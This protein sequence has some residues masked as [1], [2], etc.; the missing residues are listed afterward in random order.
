MITIYSP[1]ET[2]FTTNGL[3]VLQPLSCDLSITINEVW[4]IEL[5]QPI[6]EDGKYKTIEKNNILK[7]TDI[8]VVREQTNTYQLFRIYDTVNDIITGTVKAIAFPVAFEAT[9]DAII[10]E[11]KCAKKTA[12]A[13]LQDI[14]TYLSEHGVTKYTVTSDYTGVTARQRKG[15]WTNT[16][17]IAA[18]NGSDDGS[19]INHWGGEVAYDNYHIIVNGKLGADSNAEIRCGK[20]LTG[21]SVDADMSG[22]VTR[23]YPIS[24]DNV[25]LQ[26]PEGNAT[27]P[28]V[29][30][31]HLG[32]YP[33]V[34]AAFIKTDDKLVD[35][36]WEANAVNTDAAIYTHQAQIAITNKVKEYAQTLWVRIC[37]GEQFNNAI[38]VEPEWLKSVLNDVVANLQKYF[39]DSITHPTW[40]NLIKTCIKDG[41]AWIKDEEI[42]D[43]SW[44][45]NYT[46]GYTYGNTTRTFKNQYVY[47]DKRYRYFNP[48]GEYEPW[49]DVSIMDWIQ[50]KNSNTKEKFG[51][52]KRYMA[53]DTHVY[54]W[55]GE[56]Q[57]GSTA[58]EYW[59]DADGM[60]DGV[61]ETETEWDWHDAGT[62]WWF[63]EDGASESDKNKYAHDCWLYIW[64]SS[65]GL[66]YFDEK[67]KLVDDLTISNPNWDWREA[68]K[69]GKYYFGDSDKT[70]NSVYLHDQWLRIDGIWRKFDSNG[71][72][73]KHDVIKQ[74]L[75]TALKNAMN[76]GLNSVIT[77]QRAVLDDV[78]YTSMIEQCNKKFEEGYDLPVINITANIVDLSKTAEYADFAD[79]ET[80]HLGDRIKVIDYV[81]GFHIYE[82]VVGLKYDCIR[83]YNTEVTINDPSRLLSQM[84]L[85]SNI[86]S[87]G[88][89]TTRMDYVAGDNV[90][91]NNNV[92]NVSTPSGDVYA[93]DQVSVSQT[94]TRGR[95]IAG[96]YVNGVETPIYGGNDVSITPRLNQGTKVADYSIDG[97]SGSL[98]APSGL[99]Y[100]VET[101]DDI[102]RVGQREGL[103]GDDS[104]YFTSA[105]W[106]NKSTSTY[107]EWNYR[108]IN[109]L[110]TLAGVSTANYVLVSIYPTAVD[111]K[112]QQYGGSWGDWETP[113]EGTEYG[114]FGYKPC[115]R[116]Y[117][118]TYK[119]ITWYAARSYFLDGL[120][121]TPFS[122]IPQYEEEVQFAKGLIDTAHAD[123]YIDDVFGISRLTHSVY[124]NDDK[125]HNYDTPNRSD[126]WWIGKDG[127]FN[128][129]DFV[130][131]GTSI[132]G[133]QDVEVDGVSVVSNHVAEIDLSGKQ[134]ALIA[135]TNIDIGADGKTISATDTTYDE[136]TGATALA[137][138]TY[139]LVTKPL[140][141]DQDKVLHGDGTWRE[142]QG[143]SSEIVTSIIE[144]TTNFVTKY[145]SSQTVGWSQGGL[146]YG[147]TD[148]SNVGAQAVYNQPISSDVK[149]V[150]FKI[151]TNLHYPPSQ[152]DDYKV[153]IGVKSTY[154]ATNFA[155]PTDNDWL[156][157]KTY[158]VENGVFE[159][160]LEV[161][162]TGDYY[163]YI[164]GNSWNMTLFKLKLV[165]YA[166]GGGGGSTITYGVNPPS[167]SAND[168]DLHIVLD[169]AN[170][171]IAEFL[172]MVNTWNL[173]SGAISQFSVVLSRTAHNSSQSSVYTATAE[174]DVLVFNQNMN[175]EASNKN[176]TAT[177]ATTGTLSYEDT[178]STNFDNPNRN[179]VSHIAVVHLQAGETVT[180]GNSY[181]GN[182]TTQ[183]HLV[184]LL[185]S[186]S[187]TGISRK[188]FGAKADNSYSSA[189]TYTLPEANTYFAIGFQCRGTG[190]GTQ[191]AEISC[192]DSA[193]AEIEEV[194]RADSNVS[195]SV[196]IVK[197][198]N[199]ITFDWG[200]QNDYA[201]KG[202]AVY[203]LN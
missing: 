164:I 34:R 5:I 39:T 173:I 144:N 98:Y 10:E 184:L 155:N 148:N 23:L 13:A 203:K 154:D 58:C 30:S 197:Y 83:G 95:K 62:Y 90:T 156:V 94:I 194:K 190:G 18:I 114:D 102:Y 142:V 189:Q 137:D 1:S 91:I 135:G 64:R 116:H 75:I 145:N 177:I 187:V 193:N 174:C 79:L 76:T 124:Y 35:T 152:T 73:V 134:D 92:I 125:I 15:S 172:Y 86:G 3:A 27:V 169:N 57:G 133:V 43:Y 37:A 29:D 11:L 115:I 16:N 44:D 69:G 110:P 175:G 200:S 198:A 2:N 118:F 191:Y 7:I 109:N 81:H 42:E 107:K 80:I 70:Q 46:D 132:V 151:S 128:G 153:C 171:K 130:I 108:K 183:L 112:F 25:R 123:G 88:S 40:K 71:L 113:V 131:D 185:N 117:S 24:S 103:K 22:V 199:Q 127:T 47:V 192:S 179:Q 121:E 147:C 129:V 53:K 63:G 65:R 68:D 8:P 188:I 66:Y 160:D 139:G 122:N 9:Y 180:L 54:T 178:Y 67:G 77:A 99:Q 82:R 202:Y 31:A 162:T 146:V 150:R 17:L 167:G 21:L 48:M 119:G 195:V 93:G 49:K 96:I 143:G 126:K 161:S 105:F 50:P 4:S 14:M 85:T 61:S 74:A 159:G 157:K 141:G 33:Y 149:K 52:D 6:D 78:L 168:G 176:L 140:A 186:L 97:N 181:E 165:E 51:D 12:T 55:N 26:R 59:F 158:S 104:Y 166:S 45:G 56:H 120:I 72:N 196:A 87:S 163:I 138:G 136:F 28:Y 170:N 36:T 182:Y 100:W 201:T 41:F 19:I 32:D 106:H 20:N 111:W 101:E 84:N 60:W 38:F 89:G